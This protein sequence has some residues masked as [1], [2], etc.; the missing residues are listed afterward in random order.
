MSN[1]ISLSFARS[2][3]SHDFGQDPASA[4]PE[5][6]LRTPVAQSLE[7]DPLRLTILPLCASTPHGAPARTPRSDAST[8]DARPPYRSLHLQIEG[9]NRSCSLDAER[10]CEKWTL[11]N[12]TLTR[13]P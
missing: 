11:E 10:V 8:F 7:R 6:A 5:G 4:E 9:E 3:F 12:S 2:R 1:Q 13:I